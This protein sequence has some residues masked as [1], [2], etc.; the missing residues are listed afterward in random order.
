MTDFRKLTDDLSVAPQLRIEDLDAARAAGFR[1]IINNRPDH[2]DMQQPTSEQMAAH[3][4]SLGLAYHYLPVISG[5]ITGDNVD[6]FRT[7]LEQVDGPVLAFCRSGTRCTYLWALSQAGQEDA[8]RLQAAAAQ[9]GYDISS[10]VPY[11]KQAGS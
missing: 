7:L 8:G 2:E 4:T 9:A 10:L 11:L 1:T 3:A 6:D 5:Q